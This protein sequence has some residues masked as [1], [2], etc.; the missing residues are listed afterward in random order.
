[1]TIGAVGKI[2]V[3]KA[4]EA[5]DLGGAEIGQDPAAAKAK[6]RAELTIAGICDLY[7]EEGCDTK[8]ASTIATDRGRI[9]RHI[10]PLMGRKESV[11]S[12][13]PT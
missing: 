5:Q 1:M 7:L 10:K 3:E 4:R 11:K 8:K 2:E 12:H 6:A 9:E 13:G